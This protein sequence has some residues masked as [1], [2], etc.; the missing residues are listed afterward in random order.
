[1]RRLRRIGLIAAIAAAAL[2]ATGIGSRML[3]EARLAAR[4]EEEAIPTVAIITPGR[5][6]KDQELVLPGDIQAW[7]EAP[8]HARVGGYLKQWYQDIGAHVKSGQLLAEIDTPDLDQQ[9]AQAEADLAA[10]QAKLDLADLTSKRWRALLKTDSVSQQETDERAGDAEAKK[11]DVN[12]AR[13]NVDRL[14]ALEA[15]KRIVAPFD[16][17]VTARDTDVGALINAGGG[18]GP[19][20]FKVADV[21][22]MRIYVRAPQAMSGAI[23]TGDIADVRLPQNPDADFKAVVVTSSRAINQASRTLLIELQADNPDGALQ[24]G[25]YAEVHFRLANSPNAM[26][27]PSTATLFREHGLEVATVGAGD[28]VVLKPIR[29]ARD[30]GAQLIIASGLDPTDRVI[31]SPP[32][33]LAEGD[34]VRPL[35][36]VKAVAAK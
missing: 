7:F 5:G 23:V 13:A 19:E 2:A 33:S 3:G 30:L 12:A 24:P 16:G 1:M 18:A 10:A 14:M 29:V 36:P 6:L 11:A 28:R 4:T 22:K 15:F 25:A 34:P 35:E 8:I 20:L 9:L 31:D 32:D 26:T 17:I 27:L 21:H